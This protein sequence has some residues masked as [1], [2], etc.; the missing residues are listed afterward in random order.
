MC[1][2]LINSKYR[3]TDEV[4]YLLKNGTTEKEIIAAKDSR[5]DIRKLIKYA[6][7]YEYLKDI[8]Y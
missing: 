2:N 1:L 4:T 8:Y 6:K 3:N 7:A 5:H